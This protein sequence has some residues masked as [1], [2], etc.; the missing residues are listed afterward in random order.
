MLT[1]IGHWFESGSKDFFLQTNGVALQCNFNSTLILVSYIF[2]NFLVQ[3]LGDH[4]L[5]MIRVLPLQ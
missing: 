3:V 4:I 1:S 5:M 2:C